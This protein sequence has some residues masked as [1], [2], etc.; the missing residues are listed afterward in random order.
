MFLGSE[1]LVGRAPTALGRADEVISVDVDRDYLPLRDGTP[2]AADALEV[3]RLAVGLE[4]SFG[5]ATPEAYI[6]ADF[7]RDGAVTS[8]DALNILRVAVGL[9]SDVQPRWVFVDAAADLA[10]TITGRDAVNYE[11]GAILSEAQDSVMLKGILLGNLDM[12]G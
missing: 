9:D 2:T 12:S 10:A 8:A 5:P 7:N 1:T 3:L 6:A 11:T 4:P